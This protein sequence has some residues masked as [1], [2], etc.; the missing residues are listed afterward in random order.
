MKRRGKDEG[1]RGTKPTRMS[2][3]WINGRRRRRRK[4]KRRL[5]WEP[6]RRPFLPLPLVQKEPIINK[7]HT[8]KR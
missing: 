2:K 7:Q 4:E 5:T 8:R 1:R 3:R 6:A